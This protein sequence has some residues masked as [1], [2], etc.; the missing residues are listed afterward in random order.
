MKKQIYKTDAFF[1][2]NR[3]SKKER[4]LRIK[5][6]MPEYFLS[7]ALKERRIENRRES[8]QKKLEEL[9]MI[10]R[11]AVSFKSNNL[12]EDDFRQEIVKLSNLTEYIEK[13]CLKYFSRVP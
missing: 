4:L 6:Q 7:I 10:K 1:L 12:T 8:R 9:R 3:D 5:E 2:E 11:I 13:I